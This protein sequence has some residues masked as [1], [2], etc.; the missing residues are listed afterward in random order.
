MHADRPFAEVDQKGKIRTLWEK[1]PCHVVEGVQRDKNFVYSKR[2]LY[3]NIQ[4]GG[5]YHIVNYDWNGRPVLTWETTRYILPESGY[6]TWDIAELTDP[7]SKRRTLLVVDSIPNAKEV[8]ENPKKFF[9]LRSLS[10]MA[11]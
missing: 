11:R 6:T 10:G 3:F 1:V 9:G 4:T 8:R 7:T 5:I 2:K